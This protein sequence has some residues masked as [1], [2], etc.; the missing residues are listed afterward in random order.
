[1]IGSKRLKKGGQASVYMQHV[2]SAGTK[3]KLAVR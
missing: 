1:M 2:G 3:G